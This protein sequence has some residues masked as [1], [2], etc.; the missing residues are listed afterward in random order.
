MIGPFQN[1]ILWA[2]K[3]KQAIKKKKGKAIV[4]C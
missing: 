3:T 4:D 1:K 2:E